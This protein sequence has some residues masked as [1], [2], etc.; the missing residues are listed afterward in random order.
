MSKILK[1]IR[2]IIIDKINNILEI[3]NR[4]NTLTILHYNIEKRYLVI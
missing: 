1:E 2:L 4:Y 3:D